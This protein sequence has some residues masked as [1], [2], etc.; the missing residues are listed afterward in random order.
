MPPQRLYSKARLWSEMPFSRALSPKF[1]SGWRLITVPELDSTNAEVM[2]C[3][4][5][6]EPEGLAVRADVQTAGRGRRGRSWES[7]NGN[8][9]LSILIDAPPTVAGQV[10]FAAALALID[11]LEIEA[12]QDLP[13]LCCKWPNDLLFKGNKIAGLL[14]EV[15]PGHDQVVVGLGVNLVPTEVTDAVYQAGSLAV[16]GIP[17]DLNVLAARTCVSLESWLDTWRKVGFIPLRNAWLARAKGLHEPIVVS[18]PN[19]ELEGRFAG[20]SADGALLLEQGAV[21]Q[22]IPAGDVFFTIDSGRDLG[23]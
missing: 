11:S 2:R 10:G 20:L 6:G 12:D 16:L 8:L 1:P 22:I 17:F 21:E 3:A 5:T 7:P 4:E 19:E 18:L 9:Y 23:A 13:D 15:V 14:L